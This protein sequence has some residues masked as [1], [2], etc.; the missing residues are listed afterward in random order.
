MTIS[1]EHLPPNTVLRLR[2]Y[3]GAASFLAQHEQLIN[4]DEDSKSRSQ[5]RLQSPAPCGSPPRF[6][7]TSSPSSL[8]RRRCWDERSQSPPPATGDAGSGTS[9]ASKLPRSVSPDPVSSPVARTMPAPRKN[10]ARR[11][12]WAYNLIASVQTRPRTLPKDCSKLF[13]SKADE[14]RFRREA[15]SEDDEA[16]HVEPQNMAE[17]QSHQPLWSPQ[18]ERK[19]YLISKAVIVFG[20]TKTTYGGCAA[21][22][23]ITSIPSAE[24]LQTKPFNFD[25]AAFW[26]GDLTWS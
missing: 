2:S 7:P 24:A 5:E 21:E 3:R 8:P 25:D 4:V 11:V 16:R 17:E 14:K 15:E 26:N 9:P 1:L 23:A 12:S 13:Y 19:D 22:A 6:R 20:Q 10:C 18:K